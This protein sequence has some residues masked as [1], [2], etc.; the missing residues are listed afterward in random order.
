MSHPTPAPAPIAIIGGGPC[1]LTFARF[2]EL[3]GVD[4]V[5]FERDDPSSSS[6]A[7]SQGGTLDLHAETGQAALQ[8]AG[9]KDEFEK[10]ARREA[11]V[12]TVH[13]YLG[14]NRFSSSDLEG[15]GEEGK[16][17]RED[18]DR[19]EIDRVQLRQI[20]LDSIP[21]HRVRWGKALKSV[22]RD[23]GCKSTSPGA[24]GWVLRFADGETET[25]FRMIVGADGAWSKVRPL[26]CRRLLSPLF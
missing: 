5:I 6:S 15:D 8:A 23:E 4:Y 16:N 14:K 2:L 1:G 9:L 20:L 13:D 21:A 17:G 18:P 19:P 3:A 7:S 24:G 12:Y 11:A 10:L 25:G 26:V 22:E